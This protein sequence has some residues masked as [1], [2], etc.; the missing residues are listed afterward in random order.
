MDVPEKVDMT[1]VVD[2][3]NIQRYSILQRRYDVMETYEW[4]VKKRKQGYLAGAEFQEL[5]ARLTTYF[6]EIQPT[7]VRHLTEEEFGYI[8][9]VCTTNPSEETILG[10][11]IQID[12]ILDKVGLIKVDVKTPKTITKTEKGKDL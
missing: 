5:K 6:L 1:N 2:P 11:L 10:V 8:F 7:L 3:S 12:R 9:E 4:C